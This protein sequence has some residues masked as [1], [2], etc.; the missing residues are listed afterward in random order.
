MTED[1]AIMAGPRPAASSGLPGGAGAG[2]SAATEPRR[3]YRAWRRFR[4]HKAAQA[5]AI[6]LVGLVVV[7]LF[8]PLLAPYQPDAVDM[9][10]R[11][12][13][14]SLE[15]LFGTDQLGRD[16][17]S[18]VIFGARI[19]VVI[20][21]ISVSVAIGGGLPLGAAAGFL[22]GATDRVLTAVIDFLLSFP[23]LLLAILVIA[24]FGPGLMNGM[25][26]IGV[27]LVPVFARL[28]RAE[29]LR[30]R[31]EVYVEAV[32][33]L[34]ARN[35]VILWRHVLPNAVPPIIV[36][37]TLSLATAILSASYLGFLGL[38]AQPP[39]PEWGAMLNDG[40]RFLR[41][42]THVSIFP[43]AAIVLTIL[44][45]NL[46]GDGLRDAL[47]PRSKHG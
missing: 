9:A 46:F 4:R 3:R 43:G 34:G 47:D 37:G 36:Q 39:T 32:R 35:L 7:A 24:I 29:I 21:L 15:H 45:F 27:S 17:F 10:H 12:A 23:P 5:G 20:G 18:R 40:R 14:P 8:A 30:V 2:V 22:G 41:T 31:E 33:A 6:L 44:A 13:A 28:I 42:A 16:L 19:S 11:L 1:E 38:G 25:L 26:A